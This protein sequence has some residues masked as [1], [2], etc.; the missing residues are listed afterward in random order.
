[1][2]TFYEKKKLNTGCGALIVLG[3]EWVMHNSNSGH[4]YLKQKIQLRY[5]IW[6]IMTSY[7]ILGPIL[8]SI[9]LEITSCIWVR[10]SNFCRISS[11]CLCSIYLWVVTRSKFCGHI[12]NSGKIAIPSPPRRITRL[13]GIYTTSINIKLYYMYNRE[14]EF[15]RRT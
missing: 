14:Y 3:A 11:K 12:P 9:S 6:T 8:R 1:M 7:D 5:L 15:S 2:F 10:V 4:W 13:C